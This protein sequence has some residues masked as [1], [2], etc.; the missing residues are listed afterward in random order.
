LRP[1]RADRQVL[2]RQILVLDRQRPIQLQQALGG[3]LLRSGIK[4][5]LKISA[6]EHSVTGS[7]IEALK[8]KIFNAFSLSSSSSPSTHCVSPA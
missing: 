4:K 1:R 8:A 2:R 6:A 3:D 7:T 5:I